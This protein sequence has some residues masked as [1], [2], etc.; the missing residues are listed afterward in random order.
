MNTFLNVLV[1][2]A[3]EAASK[4]INWKT[5]IIVAVIIGLIVAG[6][7]ALILKGQLTSVFKNDSA[8]DY[9]KPNSFKV[10]VSR[11]FFL[12]SKTE[13]EEKQ[14]AQPKAEAQQ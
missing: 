4:S 10:E 14:E 3:T 1:L 9:T 8:G 13:K 2:T 7:R 6:I 12:Y 11:E 5:L